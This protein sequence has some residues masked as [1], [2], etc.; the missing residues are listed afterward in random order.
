MTPSKPF[1]CSLVLAFLALGAR[2]SAQCELQ[3]LVPPGT[4][5]TSAGWITAQDGDTI[6]VAG[7]GSVQIYRQEGL[8]AF[9]EQEIPLPGYVPRF[10]TIGAL[11]LDGDVLAVAA[12]GSAGPESV[13]IFERAGGVWFLA[14]ELGARAGEVHFGREIALEGPM[15]A[16]SSYESFPNGLRSAVYVYERAPGAWQR[17]VRLDPRADLAGTY[18]GVALDIDGGRLAVGVAGT[19]PGVPPHAYVFERVGAEWVRHDVTSSLPAPRGFGTELDLRGD[20]LLVGSTSTTPGGVARLFEFDGASWLEAGELVTADALDVQGIGAVAIV[21]DDLVLVGAPWN[22]ERKVDGGAVHAFER[23]AG[24]WRPKEKLFPPAP[25]R[26]Q[27]YGHYVTCEGDLAVLGSLHAEGVRTFSARETRCRTLSAWPHEISLA[28]GGRQS[29]RLDPGREHAGRTY[30]LL[31]SASG[32]DPGFRFRGWRVPV[33]P[34][35][36]LASSLPG[37]RAAPFVDNIGVLG[38]RTAVVTIDVPAGLDL[39]L[40]GLTLHHAFLVLDH[41]VV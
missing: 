38:T 23:V 17:V 25:E 40:V 13:R 15:L 29:L 27:G 16:V 10:Y 39:A 30:W 31:G 22:D 6:A 18:I 37:R 5:S 7:D 35:A 9:A 1:P 2:G 24:T 11:A 12:R 36:Y 32:F 28:T 26:N 41:G 34:D 33:V 8:T 19:Y 3:L 21:D 4:P 20:R 14:D